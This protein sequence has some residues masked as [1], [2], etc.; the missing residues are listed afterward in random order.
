MASLAAIVDTIVQGFTSYPN[1]NGWN[2]SRHIPAFHVG[3]VTEADFDPG[4]LAQA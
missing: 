4:P 2:G 1:D 3:F